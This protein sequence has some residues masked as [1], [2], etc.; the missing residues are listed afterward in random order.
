MDRADFEDCVFELAR[1]WVKDEDGDGDVDSEDFVLYLRALYDRVFK[2]P[3]QSI[4]AW[5]KAFILDKASAKDLEMFNDHGE[6]HIG[7]NLIE[8]GAPSFAFSPTK[9]VV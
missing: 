4:A 7:A 8:D 3:F 6:G 1:S 9:H 2:E 5:W